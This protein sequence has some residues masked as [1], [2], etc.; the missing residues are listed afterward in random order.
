MGWNLARSVD[1]PET[2]QRGYGGSKQ[3]DDCC[4]T[5]KRLG[6]HQPSKRTV[7]AVAVAKV[8]RM[9]D[10]DDAVQVR[11]SYAEGAIPRSFLEALRLIFFALDP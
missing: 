2:G 3:L 7:R 10:R 6:P 8:D 9:R 4:S 1:A 11:A 5:S